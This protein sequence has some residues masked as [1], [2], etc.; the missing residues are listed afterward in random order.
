MMGFVPQKYGKALL[1]AGRP[2]EAVPLF[3]RSIAFSERK[4]G[5]HNHLIAVDL[6]DLAEAYGRMGRGFGKRLSL[7]DRA[8]ASCEMSAERAKAFWHGVDQLAVA[9]QAS[10]N[11]YEEAGLFVEAEVRWAKC[12]AFCEKVRSDVGSQCAAIG[13]IGVYGLQTP[14]ED[15]VGAPP[16]RRL[17]CL[18]SCLLPWKA[19]DPDQ[20]LDS[21][22]IAL[23]LAAV[24]EKMAQAAAPGPSR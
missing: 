8:V 2:A 11:C 13:S 7:L 17:L 21:R 3:L 19:A 9:L 24:R 4:Y 1:G 5:P 23:R 10:A 20:C 22:S 6:L 14:G 15:V 16:R 18:S 12:L